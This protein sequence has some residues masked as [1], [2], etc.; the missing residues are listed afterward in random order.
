MARQVGAKPV[1]IP[2]V[3]GFPKAP[4]WKFGYR[5]ALLRP[6]GLLSAPRWKGQAPTGG[7]WA[8]RAAPA[9]T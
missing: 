2:V 1:L 6:S 4:K 8:G 3:P 5:S 9:T 7:P